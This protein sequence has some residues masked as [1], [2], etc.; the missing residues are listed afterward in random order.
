MG[1][2]PCPRVPVYHSAEVLGR[3]ICLVPE[4]FSELKSER[5]IGMDE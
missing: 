1:S 5:S 3:A 4:K 2:Y